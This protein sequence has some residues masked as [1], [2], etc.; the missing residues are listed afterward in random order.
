V[1]DPIKFYA[2]ENI[3]DDVVSA[4][5]RR[6][7]DVLKTHH[8]GKRGALDPEQLAFATREGRV[9]LTVIGTL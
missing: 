8:A 3:P 6:Q 5:R 2:D 1:D 9:L 4:L 7:V